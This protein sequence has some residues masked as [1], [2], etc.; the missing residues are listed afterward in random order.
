M[1]ATGMPPAQ[2]ENFVRA[3]YLPQTKQG[4]WHALCRQCDTQPGTPQ[5]AFGGARG[6]GKSHAVLAQ[7]S[8]GDCQRRD[9]LKGLLLRKV[10]KAGRESFED[11]RLSVLKHTPHKYNR[12]S[13]I[14]TFPNGSRIILG[15]YKDEKDVDAYLGL[16]YDVIGVEE[17][18]TLSLTKIKVV[19]TC[20]RTSRDDWTPRMYYNA[21]PGGIGHEWFKRR[22]VSEPG[23]P[24]FVAAT[25]RDNAFLNPGYVAT[26]D[27]LTGWLRRAWRDGDWD[28]H[29]GTFFTNYDSKIHVIEPFVI[30]HLG[31]T[32]YLAMDYGWIHPSTFLLFAQDNKKDLY[33]I[34]GCAASRRLPAA[35]HNKVLEMLARWSLRPQDIRAFV[36]GTDSWSPNEKGVTVAESYRALGWSPTKAKMSR[37]PGATE[38]LRRLGDA[39]AS[40]EPT[41]WIFSTCH[42][43]I[44]QLPTLQHDPLRP[45][46]VLKVNID[47]DGH[48]GDDWYDAAR[49]AA[50]LLAGRR[51][52]TFGSVWVPR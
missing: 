8:L 5:V 27:D 44:E 39:G 50:M 3:G 21:N 7:M 17:A 52:V 34:D 46:D 38:L 28:A 42:G 51:A 19:R 18:T 12:S 45:E 36:M 14:L 31:W 6:P 40:I 1:L 26:L 9:G 24:R 32:F 37:V 25:Y 48:G 41:M 22:F 11:L 47:E 10:G 15:H 16:Q 43:L 2:I 23:Q 30:D 33:Y 35:H 29:A 20:C 49:Y 13:G 4:A